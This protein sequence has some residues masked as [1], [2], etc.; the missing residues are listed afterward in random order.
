MVVGLWGVAAGGC[1]GGAATAGDA[2]AG[3]DAP[4][5]VDGRMTIDGSPVWDGAHPGDF[6]SGDV[7]GVT[8]RVEVELKSGTVGLAAGQIWVNAGPL[9]ASAW[10]LYVS[11]SVGVSECPSDW[12]ALFDAPGGGDLRSDG[13]GSCSVNV[14]AAAPALGDVIEGTFSATLKTMTSTPQITAVVTNGAFHV[15]RN[16]Q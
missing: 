11:N 4:L 7:D 5:G 13:G 15:T 12:I 6:I 10:N 3:G 14:T 1:G 9:G 2:A 8:V 16:F